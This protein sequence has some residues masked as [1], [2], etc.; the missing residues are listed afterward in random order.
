MF[1]LLNFDL[2][3]IDGAVTPTNLFKNHKNVFYW[4][5]DYWGENGVYM[6]MVMSFRYFIIVCSKLIL[7]PDFRVYNFGRNQQRSL[8]K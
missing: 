2:E 8:K 4:I 3:T 5:G 6:Y 7:L 1:L